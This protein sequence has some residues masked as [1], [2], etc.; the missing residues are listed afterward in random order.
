MKLEN[1]CLVPAD[2]AITWALVM[3]IP[4]VAACVPG[5]E[6]V[7][8]ASD[9]RFQ[10]VMKVRIGP[11][12]LNLSGTIQVLERDEDKGEASFLVEASD[13]RVGGAVRTNITIQLVSPADHQTELVIVSDTNFM[14]RLGELGQPII[15]RK[16]NTT[17]QDFARNLAQQVSSP[18]A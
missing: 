17:M 5:L 14:G 18:P 3:D 13:R 12:S 1:R 7:T 8:V 2:R 16:A 6:D 9:D 15:R 10:A 11:I 4:R